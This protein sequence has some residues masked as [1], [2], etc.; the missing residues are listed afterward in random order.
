[1][2]HSVDYIVRAVG[3]EHIAE[4]SASTENTVT[5]SAARKWLRNGIPEIHWWIFIERVGVTANDIYQA[6]CA[7]RQEQSERALR[8]LDEP[9]AA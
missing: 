8:R 6:N 5:A 3:F 7:L 2:N 4:A 9:T 1:M